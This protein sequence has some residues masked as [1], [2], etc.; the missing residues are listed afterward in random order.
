MQVLQE[1]FKFRFI[2]MNQTKIFFQVYILP[3][4]PFY[5]LWD[6]QSYCRYKTQFLVMRSLH[7][8]NANFTPEYVG[9]L[10]NNL[11]T[12][13][14]KMLVLIYSDYLIQSFSSSF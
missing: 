12:Y 9:H 11:K 13:M 6:A 8:Q 4:T 10:L 3:R 1:E 5:I 7:H 2:S 14:V